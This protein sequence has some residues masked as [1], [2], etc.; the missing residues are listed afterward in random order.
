MLFVERVVNPLLHKLTSGRFANMRARYYRVTLSN[1]FPIDT[2]RL[3]DA[4]IANPNTM[5]DWGLKDLYDILGDRLT[6]LFPYYRWPSLWGLEE[7]APSSARPERE[8]RKP[9]DPLWEESRRSRSNLRAR[10][11]G[12]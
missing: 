7:E 3:W 4:E 2:D 12:S 11:L 6:D 8:R 10:R 1:K 5:D 9:F